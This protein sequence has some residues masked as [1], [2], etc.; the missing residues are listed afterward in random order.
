MQLVFASGK[1]AVAER[2]KEG[3]GLSGTR[4]HH[5]GHLA[6]ASACTSMRLSEKSIEVDIAKDNW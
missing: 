5:G 4:G 1:T 6:L 2:P 3:A